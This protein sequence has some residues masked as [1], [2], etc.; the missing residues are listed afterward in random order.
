MQTAEEI[1]RLYGAVVETL[2]VN[3]EHLRQRAAAGFITVT[4]LA[5]SLVREFGLPFRQ[6]HRVVS[7]M[8]SYALK[9]GFGPEKIDRDL[10]L[11]ISLEV[12]GEHLEVSEDIIQHALQPAAFVAAR[13]TLGG[14]AP[15]ATRAVLENQTKALASDQKWFSD[16]QKKLTDSEIMLTLEIDRLLSS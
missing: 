13:T 1:L 14:V 10:L 11:Q 8:V 7:T 15:V 3:V 6:A 12:L 5:D 2:K 4:E 9:H 16:T